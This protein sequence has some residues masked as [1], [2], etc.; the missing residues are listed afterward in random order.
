M[1]G[2]AAGAILC[3]VLAG[4]IVMAIC[5]V[6]SAADSGPSAAAPL[7]PL[8]TIPVPAVPAPVPA[9]PA[10][11]PAAP[12][13][14]PTAASTPSDDTTIAPEPMIREKVAVLRGID[15][16][17]GRVSEFTA[18]VGS[19]VRFG[20]LTIT[21][22][23]CEKNPPIERPENAAFLQIYENRRGE[24]ETRIFSG[25]MFS[26]S[27]S[28]SSLEHPVYDVNVLGCESAAVAGASPGGASVS[29]VA[30]PTGSSPLS[31]EE[32]SAR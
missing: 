5:G 3:T 22:R 4:A 26:S 31:D 15:K 29:T 10:P 20:T 8:V 23:D 24:K 11:P 25:W 2:A 6:A 14:A 7:P 28:L 1:T 12:Q 30:A 16:I 27:P 32:K 9:L 17:S 13:P 21:V 19:S 18:P